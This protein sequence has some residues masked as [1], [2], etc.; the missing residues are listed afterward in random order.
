MENRLQLVETG[1]QRV[2]KH[3]GDAAAAWQAELNVQGA[4]G[5]DQGGDERDGPGDDPQPKH[6]RHPSHSGCCGTP[7]QSGKRNPSQFQRQ[8]GDF[9]SLTN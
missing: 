1:L 8:V 3:L 5:Q 9:A 7:F 6:E 2:N 4:A